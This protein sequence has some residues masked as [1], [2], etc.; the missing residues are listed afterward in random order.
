MKTTIKKAIAVIS[1]I[2][3][4]LATGISVSANGFT[5]NETLVNEPY[6]DGAYYNTFNNKAITV[7]DDGTKYLVESAENNTDVFI[8]NKDIPLHWAESYQWNVNNKQY[9]IDK[10]ETCGT[11]NAFNILV[12]EVYNIDT[13]IITMEYIYIAQISGNVFV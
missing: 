6:A 2:A 7:S 11:D 12:I 4:I 1:V 5:T 9:T 13:D 10:I 3:S 8:Y